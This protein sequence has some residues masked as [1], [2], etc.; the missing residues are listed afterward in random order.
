[1]KPRAWLLVE[2]PGP[3]PER[4]EEITGPQGLVDAIGA[5]PAAGVRPQLIRRPGRGR[6]ATP[7]VRV[8]IGWSYGSDVWIETR[9]LDDHGQLAEIDFA[10][11]AAGRRPGWGES[12]EEPVLLVCTHG[13][14]NACCARTGAP[15]ARRLASRFGAL[16]WETTHVGGDRYAANLVCLP[17]AVYYGNLGPDEAE[18]AVSAYLNGEVV[19]DNL[20]GRAGT[21]EPAQAAE[22]AVRTRTGVLDV[23]G[24]TVE[25]LSGASPHTAVVSAGGK[26]YRVVVERAEE[27]GGC[28]PEC[29]E[30]LQTHL[31]TDLTLL[32]EAALV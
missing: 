16:V 20:R 11:L 24:V 31:V 15:L 28:G 12:V 10:A 3:W 26:R 27:P 30:R 25:T 9:E 17:H 8:Y 14:R 5:A 29:R 18:T 23:A 21:P 7:P 1:M 19:L 2:H 32:N 4:V 6:R 22:H 13:R